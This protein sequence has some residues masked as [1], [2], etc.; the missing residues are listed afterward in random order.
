MEK[1]NL[2][3][4][5]HIQPNATMDEI[6]TA[7]RKLALKYHPDKYK[8]DEKDSSLH[9]RNVSVAY[10]ILSDPEKRRE[11]DNATPDQQESQINISML[12]V[13]KTFSGRY[14]SSV[15]NVLSFIYQDDTNDMENDLNDLNMSN[16]FKK[17]TNQFS[18]NFI[19]PHIV[20]TEMNFEP[21]TKSRLD[22]SGNIK[23]SLK[24]KWL[25]VPQNISLSRVIYD[26]DS[27]N[28]E[29]HKIKIGSIIN[30]PIILRNYGDYDKRTNNY[31]NAY[32]SI[33]IIIPSN[34]KI[35]NDCLVEIKPISLLHFFT[36]KNMN[37]YF[38]D[39]TTYNIQKEN[40]LY[41]YG[42]EYN[43]PNKGLFINPNTRGNYKI[44]LNIIDKEKI[45]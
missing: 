29:T 43:L 5:L 38:P 24:E 15:Q 1:K 16:I 19:S 36:L 32:V 13:I 42:T 20:N 28:L 21:I 12:N 7:Y 6:K 9:F 40:E 33:E 35:I 31:G 17:M 39:G 45:I 2:Y 14:Y 34:Y 25:N 8:G 44:Q 18:F 37:G 22:I 11:Y 10:Q 41:N 26:E 4:I 3:D 30:S 27:K 23:V